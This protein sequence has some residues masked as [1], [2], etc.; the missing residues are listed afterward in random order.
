MVLEYRD[1]GTATPAVFQDNARCLWGGY[2]EQRFQVV[3]F[4]AIELLLRGLT[5]LE[6]LQKSNYFSVIDY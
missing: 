3:S 2:Y 6:E 4:I 1:G 5:R